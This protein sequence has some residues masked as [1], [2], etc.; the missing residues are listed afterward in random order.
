MAAT[1]SRK[2][3]IVNVTPGFLGKQ[4]PSVYDN[5]SIARVDGVC[6]R[7]S[8]SGNGKENN[9]TVVDACPVIKTVML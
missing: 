5:K 9:L 7:S 4:E 8:F 2:A 1:R 3:N 6:C